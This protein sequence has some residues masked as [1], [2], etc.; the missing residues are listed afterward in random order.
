MDDGNGRLRRRVKI[1]AESVAL[2]MSC[3]YW[4]YGSTLLLTELIRHSM[5]GS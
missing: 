1:E 2:Y 5:H 3:L 4:V